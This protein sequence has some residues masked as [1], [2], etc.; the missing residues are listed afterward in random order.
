MCW[1]S[2]EFQPHLEKDGLGV[3]EGEVGCLGTL[4]GPLGKEELEWTQS[5]IIVCADQPQQ[6]QEQELVSSYH[7][8][9]Q[10]YNVNTMILK[11]KA[12]HILELCPSRCPMPEITS[13]SLPPVA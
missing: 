11:E 13:A 6:N 10:F 2:K 12:H 8:D 3:G 1:G 9:I 4:V 5:K 7:L